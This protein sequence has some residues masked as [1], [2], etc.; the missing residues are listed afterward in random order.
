VGFAVIGVALWH[1]ITRAAF[2]NGSSPYTDSILGKKIDSFLATTS[3]QSRLHLFSH[4]LVLDV[5]R[6]AAEA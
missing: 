2:V 4:A 6:K 1:V 3:S 5:G